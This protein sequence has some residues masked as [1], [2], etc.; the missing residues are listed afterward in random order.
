MNTNRDPRFEPRNGDV[1]WFRQPRTRFWQCAI[2]E[3]VADGRVYYCRSAVGGTGAAEHVWV[4]VEGWRPRGHR[5]R[6]RFPLIGER[7]VA[8][9]SARFRPRAAAR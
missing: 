1:V 4:D 3:R 6:L 8:I 7:A 5:A 9:G 2:V